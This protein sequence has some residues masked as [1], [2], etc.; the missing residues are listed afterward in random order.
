MK[1]ERLKELVLEYMKVWN[2]GEENRLDQYAHPG[3]EVSYT[4]FEEAYRGIPS[5]KEMLR[6]TH[7]Y[8]PDMRI[9]LESSLPNENASGVT[10][11]WSYEGTHQNGELFGVQATGK[12]VSVRG[13]SYLE[14]QEGLIKSETG[15]VDNLS[16]I[17]QLGAIGQ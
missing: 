16:L 1:S 15:I 11:F 3:I 2:A 7:H 8:F 9:E 5:Y 6:M 14:V 4:H 10:V 13:M 17:M 12:L